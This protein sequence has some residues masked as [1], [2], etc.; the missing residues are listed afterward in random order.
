MT[1]PLHPVPHQLP[2]AAADEFLPPPGAWAHQLGVRTAAAGA[3]LLLLAC[4]WPFDESVRAPGSV[5]PRGENSPVQALG[6]GRL[7]RVLVSPNQQVR[8]GQLLAQLDL[9]A[10]NSQQRQLQRERAQLQEQ[11][12]QAAQQFTDLQAQSRSIHRL[13]TTQ[14]ATARGGVA[15]ALAGSRFQDRE[16]QRLRGLAAEGAIPQLLLEEKEAGVAVAKS[17]LDQARLGVGEQRARLQAEQARLRQSLSATI[18][19][20]AELERQLAAVDG[21]LRE[22]ALARQQSRLLAPVDGTVVETKLRYPGQVLQP[23]EVVATLAPKGQPLAIKVQLPSRDVAPLKS[24]Q[25]AYLRVG[26]CPHTDFGVL[27]GRIQAIAADA[28][29]GRYAVTISPVADHLV[30]GQRR[31]VLRPGMELDADLVIRRGTVMGLLLRK[32]RLL[33][34]T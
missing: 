19:A 15:Q 21:R 4:V 10:I 3:A 34:S 24:G 20:R 14:I 22:T 23:G 16:L 27:D 28:V 18:S 12:H 25:R 8:A 2:P 6:G 1:T 29:D 32:L 33:A 5:R 31:C 9:E 30:R 7:Q 11:L 17:Q 26:S 13:M